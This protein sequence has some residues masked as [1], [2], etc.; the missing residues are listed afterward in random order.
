MS[1]ILIYVQNEEIEALKPLA[2]R[3]VK[4]G[5]MVNFSAIKY[6]EKGKCDQALTLPKYL[7]KI[8]ALF[9][10]TDVAVKAIE[11]DEP[12]AVKQV[13]APE[14]VELTPEADIFSAL[15]TSTHEAPAV[16]AE[17]PAEEVNAAE[18][19]TDELAAKPLVADAE[20]VQ[21]TV[22]EVAAKT[23]SRRRR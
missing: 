11:D 12:S 1:R 15:A 19:V 3:L 7:D 21:I 9:A 6:L 14:V 4:K 22:S 18:V 5:A 16:T 10:G 13:A 23:P 20:E 8:K 2:E 17:T